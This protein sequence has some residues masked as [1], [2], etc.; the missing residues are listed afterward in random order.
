MKLLQCILVIGLIVGITASASA[1]EPGQMG[2]TIAAGY[3]SPLGNFADRFDGIPIGKA[4]IAYKWKDN[5]WIQWLAEYNSYD[6]S[7]NSTGVS[8]ATNVKQELVMYNL[9][10][11]WQ[12]LFLSSPN[13]PF[14]QFGAGYYYTKFTRGSYIGVEDDTWPEVEREEWTMGGNL[15]LGYLIAASSAFHIYGQGT[16]NFVF[17]DIWPTMILGMDS[18]E[19]IQGL[20]VEIGVRILF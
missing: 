15:G 16:Y 20:N 7:W 9:M 12:Y 17:A 18:V 11:N 2:V 19:A 13:T 8:A 5:F 14:L 6:K 3:S 1:L 10:W 4:G